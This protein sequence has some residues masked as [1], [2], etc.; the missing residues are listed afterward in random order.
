VAIGNILDKILR[1]A[2]DPGL[3]ELARK[4]SLVKEINRTTDEKS[5]GGA[6]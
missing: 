5:E 4:T 3:R 1:R 6:R 2:Q